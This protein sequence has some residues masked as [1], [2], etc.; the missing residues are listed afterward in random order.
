MFV[1]EVFSEKEP[2]IGTDML[3]VKY[4]YFP[5]KLAVVSSRRAKKSYVGS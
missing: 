3:G 2:G 5:V 4:N 1:K